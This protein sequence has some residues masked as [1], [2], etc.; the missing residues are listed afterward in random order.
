[1]PLI[2]GA[3][4]LDG[5]KDFKNRRHYEKCSARSNYPRI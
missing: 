2:P 1:M 3:E 4:C 5:Y